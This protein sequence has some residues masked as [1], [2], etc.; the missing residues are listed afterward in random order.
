MNVTVASLYAASM[1]FAPILL[2]ATCVVANLSTQGMQN[3]PTVVEMSMNVKY[4]NILAE[5]APSVRI[6]ILVTT[7]NVL[8][9]IE[10]NQ[11]L[12]LLANR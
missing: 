4:W 6:L 7:A 1:P 2:A 3:R 5:S 8:K 9:V 10:L 12:K 11:G